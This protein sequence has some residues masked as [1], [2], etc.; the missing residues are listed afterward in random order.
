MYELIIQCFNFTNLLSNPT[1]LFNLL[2]RGLE[3]YIHKY[4]FPIKK[5]KNQLNYKNR[6]EN[7]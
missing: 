6:F 3:K 4:M 2:F 7:D 5:I 1:L